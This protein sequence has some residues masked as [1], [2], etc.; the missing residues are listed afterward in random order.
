MPTV[1]NK[2]GESLVL[3]PAINIWQINFLSFCTTYYNI[4]RVYATLRYFLWNVVIPN[5][6]LS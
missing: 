2:M 6:D 3:K 4:I 1:T 5:T